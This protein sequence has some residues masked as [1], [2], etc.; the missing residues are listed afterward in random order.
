M[1][2]ILCLYDHSSGK[3]EM[4]LNLNIQIQLII[5]DNRSG[6]GPLMRMFP[7]SPLCL[8]YPYLSASIYCVATC[9]G[10]LLFCVETFFVES[11]PIFCR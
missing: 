5:K 7:Q 4:A 6:T 1:Q 11:F 8:L 2:L 3:L 10:R 9:T